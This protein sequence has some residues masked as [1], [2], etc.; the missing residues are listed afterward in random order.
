V[1]SVTLQEMCLW[2]EA[3]DNGDEPGA[4]LSAFRLCLEDRDAV[5]HLTRFAGPLEPSPDVL[6][7]LS[8]GHYL[9]IQ[10]I[11]VLSKRGVPWQ[12]DPPTPAKVQ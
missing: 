7:V 10:S 9:A 11:D 12:N 6:F 3:E 8:V 2:L 5:G 4:L 1:A